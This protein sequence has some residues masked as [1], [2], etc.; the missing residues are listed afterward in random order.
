M[1]SEDATRV[2]DGY[3]S[4][5]KRGKKF[6]DTRGYSKEDEDTYSLIMRDKERLLSFGSKIRFIFSH[7]ALREGWDNPNVFQICTLRDRG[8]SKIT[9]RQ[10]IGRGLRLCVDQEGNRVHGHR[11]NT[12]SVIVNE[13]WEQFVQE[14]QN[15]IEAESGIKF[16][17]IHEG[18]FSDVVIQIVDSTVY[19][20]GLEKSS[21]LYVHFMREGY[22]DNEGKVR[23]CLRIALR[24]GK[25]QM[26][27]IFTEYGEYV[28]DQILNRLKS[29]AGRLKIRN[30]DKKTKVKPNKQVLYSAEFKELWDR[31]KHKTTF[32]VKFDSQSLVEKC[33]ESLDRNLRVHRGKI[34]Y[35]KKNL[36]VVVGE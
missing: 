16:G 5:D 2:H 35:V 17:V 9:P 4:A 34:H 24:D 1:Y 26:P 22:F 12:L 30:E 7:S 25:V 20:L 21:E 33:I 14:L 8:I 6:K 29:V 31:V 27:E 15:E 3:F 10:Q 13:S 18:I 23:K 19:L 36:R 11:V 28:V 32:L